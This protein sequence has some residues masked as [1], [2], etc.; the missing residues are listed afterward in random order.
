M[1]TYLLQQLQIAAFLGL[2]AA[3]LVAVILL[4]HIDLSVP[5]TITT[6]AMMAAAPRGGL[7]ARLG[8]SGRRVLRC[9]IGL[10]NGLGV[11]FLRIPSMIFT[12]GANAVLQGLDGAVHGRPCTPRTPPPR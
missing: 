7:S 11:A 4:G 2:A 12:L 5:W 8:H 9:L 6:G 3:G 1:P 10:V